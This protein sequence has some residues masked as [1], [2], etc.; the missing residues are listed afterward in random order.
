MYRYFADP[1]ELLEAVIGRSRELGEDVA[2]IHAIGEGTLDHRIDRFVETRM[3]VYEAVGPTF[4]ATVANAPRMPRIREAL[5]RTR[6]DLRR[7][8]ELQFA[9]ELAARKSDDRTR[10]IAVGDVL[11]QLDSIDYL[12]R[13]RQFSVAETTEMLRTSLTS[14]LG[15]GEP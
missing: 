4:R 10:L 7:Q 14:I 3:R 15:D 13:H 1:A 9:P 11:T 12:R 8:F 5:T 6:D 2:R